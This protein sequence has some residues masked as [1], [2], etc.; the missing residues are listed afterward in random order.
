MRTWWSRPTRARPP[1]PTSPTCWRPST[2]SGWATPS[3]RVA[4]TATTTRRSA[5]R[6]AASGSACGRTSASSRWTPTRRRS[7]S[8]ASATWGA[9]CSATGC[10]ARRTS[11]CAPPSTTS[12]SSSTRRRTRRAASPSASGCSAQARAGTPTTRR[13][14]RRA[15]PCWR[16]RLDTDAVDNSAGVDLSD[17]EVNLKICLGVALEDGRLSPEARN[18]LLASVTDEVA[19]RVLAH[20]RAQSRLLS[21]DQVRSRRRLADF[22]ALMTELERAA[23]LDRALEALPDADALRARRGTYPGL[24]RPEL[25][26]LMAYA[27]IHLQHALLASPL[28]ADPLLAPYLT[29][30]F[31]AVVA[32]RFPDAVRAHPL[33]PEIVATELANTLVDEMGATFVHRVTRDTGTTVAEAVRAWTIAW[34]VAGGATLARAIA[35]GGF[36]LEAETTCR[37]VLERTG[38]RVTK[39]VLANTDAARPADEV[40]AELSE[41]TLRVRDRL[42]D[43][44]AGAEAE[45]FAKLRSELEI[46]GLP[47]ALANQLATADW[48]TGA[49]DVVTVARA[50][51]VDPEAAAARYYGLGP[52]LDFAWLLARLAEAGEDDRWQERA[53]EG[54]IEDV[55]RARRRLARLALEGA[56]GAAARSLGK[57]Q[58]LIRDLRA[59]PRT[60]LAALQVVVRELR[61]AAERE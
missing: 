24:T 36:A 59:A 7:P 1:S 52:Q 40:A 22:R 18:A 25:A 8:P 23:G 58:D 28:P 61:R 42:P 3:P 56:D 20:N 6:R 48:L 19:A 32:E 11:G 30:Y 43:W 29:G 35:E 26:V 2:A 13:G 9:T 31:P 16:G 4:R 27:K 14:S 55:L 12:T 49:L 17:H 5:S 15:A 41:A 57:V 54:L 33:G 34:A 60:S 51:G 45:S 38:E 21:L 46:A 50:A 47:A 10:C 37:F 44:I 53:G 39:W